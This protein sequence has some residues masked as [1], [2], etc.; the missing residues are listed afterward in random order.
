MARR[1]QRQSGSNKLFLIGEKDAI[2]SPVV[3]RA[4]QANVI[5]A[6][7]GSDPEGVR[8]EFG[9]G[10][11]RAKGLPRS[12]A[13]FVAED[14]QPFGEQ[15]RS[16]AFRKW[17]GT[18]APV[19]SPEAIN[20]SDFSG[21]GPF[22]MRAYHGTTHEFEAFDASQKGTKEGQFGAVNYF[23]S[24]QADADQNYAGEGPDL[25]QRIEMRAESI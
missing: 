20:D 13:R 3:K 8:N 6:S 5:T 1:I 15:E 11:S 14:A 12:P 24:S 22:V 4:L 19:I 21:P 9:V 18:I 7:Y 16:A 25:T 10:R 23:T 2:T 17:A